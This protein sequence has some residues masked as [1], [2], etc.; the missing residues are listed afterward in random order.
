MKIG[1]KKLVVGVLVL[2]TEIVTPKG[3]AME[4][5]GSNCQK[6]ES[7]II[8]P[9]CC[10]DQL[11]ASIGQHL[12]QFSW[13]F[14]EGGLK[15]IGRFVEKLEF[16]CDIA[17]LLRADSL[18]CGIEDI[19]S[20]KEAILDLSEDYG[21]L[22]SIV[23]LDTPIG[24][25]NVFLEEIAHNFEPKMLK[26]SFEELS[27]YQQQFYVFSVIDEELIQYVN[28]QNEKLLALKD[29]SPEAIMNMIRTQKMI[30][31]FLMEFKDG[32]DDFMKKIELER[33]A[34]DLML[35]SIYETTRNITSKIVVSK[36]PSLIR[37]FEI[38][39]EKAVEEGL[40]LDK[41]RREKEESEE[42]AAEE[43][44]KLY[45]ERKEK[46]HRS[47][48]LPNTAPK[49]KTTWFSKKSKTT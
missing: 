49:E 44:R 1:L 24:K 16:L 28:K 45:A 14:A 11:R 38:E 34:F 31:E 40:K 33:R 20:F 18:V 6:L 27:K 32:D 30:N 21:K 19:N 37:Q 29:K 9:R 12:E 13:M 5:E 41:E 17:I 43:R 42:S 15:K 39:Y 35:R 8:L 2:A 10:D 48:G 3:G 22:K 46:I 23:D 47:D 26:F 4:I 25:V 36:F 7:M